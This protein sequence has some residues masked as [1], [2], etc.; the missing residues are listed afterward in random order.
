VN[1]TVVTSTS[2]GARRRAPSPPP[3]LLLVHQ[4]PPKPD[5]LRARVS[6]RLQRLGAV[7][8]KNSVYVLP[9]V[10]ESREDAGWLRAEIVEAGGEA[11]VCEAAFVDGLTDE[12]VKALF[13]AARAADWLAIAG[14]ARSVAAGLAASPRGRPRKGVEAAEARA[15]AERGLVRLARRAAAVEDLDF[16]RAPEREEATMAIEEARAALRRG[17]AGTEATPGENAAAAADRPRGRTWTTRRNPRVDRMSSAWLIRRF[18]D[19]EARFR[20]VDPADPRRRGELRFDM[21][22]ADF[23][24]EGDRC[25]FETLVSR[26]ARRDAALRQVAEIVHDVDLKD[27]KFGREEAAGVARLVDG[28]AGTAANDAERL[29]RGAAVF[30]ALYAAFGGPA[31]PGALGTSSRRRRRTA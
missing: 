1:G 2:D 11:L 10:E 19:P 4:I 8:I 30:E 29:E 17:A 12:E 9:N 22:D 27:A 7:A 3:W 31:P 28:I 14:E 15:R 5:A 25:T 16:F 26:F 18:V 23:G 24:H 20:F 13:R 21:A 6:R